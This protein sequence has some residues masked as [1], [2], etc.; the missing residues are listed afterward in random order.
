[1]IFTNN[2]EPPPDH[3]NQR[4]FSHA[5]GPLQLKKTKITTCP[6]EHPLNT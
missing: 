4:N 5:P 2:S 6:N 1:M 3:R